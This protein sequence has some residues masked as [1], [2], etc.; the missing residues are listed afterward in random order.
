MPAGEC[1]FCAIGTG[2]QPGH[3]VLSDDVAVAFLDTRPVFKGHVLVAPRTHV[4]TLTDL[5]APLTGPFFGR[6]QSVA[7]AVEQ[8]L[9]AGGTFVAMNNRISQSVPHLHVHVVP[10]N[11]KDGLRGF[12]WPRTRYDEPA[13]AESYALRIRKALGPDP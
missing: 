13:E 8:G 3:V 5:P 12:F 1:L 6:V 10:R 11:P 7:A 2:E 4:E 9:E